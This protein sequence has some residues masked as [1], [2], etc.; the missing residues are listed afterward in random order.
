MIT[1]GSPSLPRT[2][3][4]ITLDAGGLPLSGLL[5]E[6]DP[7]PPRAVVVALHGAGMNAGY[8]D[9][10]THPGLSLMEL[11][12]S[13]GFTV[14]AIDRP[15]YGISAACLPEGQSLA[16]QAVAVRGALDDFAAGHPVGAGFLFLAHSF[17]GKVALT[18]A[19]DLAGG[20]LLGVD[21]SGCGQ[22]YAAERDDL[23][24]AAW[25]G[26]W[27]RTWRHAYA[28]RCG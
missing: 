10:R 14:L 12:P 6:P 24:D 3:S 15:G 22:R 4:G 11:G 7:T 27:K 8:F 26:D 23:S 9:A 17:G 18:A 25:H 21:I 28:C 5:G 20:S 1:S 2:I 16:D 13:L 19:A